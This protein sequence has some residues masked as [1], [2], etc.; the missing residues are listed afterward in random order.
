M[1]RCS[2]SV[3]ASLTDRYNS[4]NFYAGIKKSK[5]NHT[6]NNPM[7]ILWCCL[8][9]GAVKRNMPGA[10][11]LPSA[12]ANSKSFQLPHSRHFDSSNTSVTEDINNV[13]VAF[14]H[15]SCAH[16]ALLTHLNRAETALMLLVTPVCLLRRRVKVREGFTAGKWNKYIH[17]C[18]PLTADSTEILLQGM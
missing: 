12:Y 15:F 6:R 10:Q 13:C 16:V 18:F 11:H 3:Q 4:C 17:V 2:C 8:T 5:R 7:K 1:R 14:I 9:F